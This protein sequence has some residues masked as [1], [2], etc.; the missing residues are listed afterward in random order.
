MPLPELQERA[1]L[2]GPQLTNQR[3]VG[4]LGDC[5]TGVGAVTPTAGGTL[6][7]SVGC[8]TPDLSANCR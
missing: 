1:A 5:G 8:G 7:A 6:T 4:Q 3:A 2:M